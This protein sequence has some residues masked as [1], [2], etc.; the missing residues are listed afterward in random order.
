MNLYELRIPKLKEREDDVLCND[1]SSDFIGR[2]KRSAVVPL[3]ICFK[4]II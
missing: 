2:F 3:V 4:Q 1:V